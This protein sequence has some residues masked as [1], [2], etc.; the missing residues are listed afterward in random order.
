[1][2]K[3][4][5]KVGKEHR[6]PFNNINY[7]EINIGLFGSSNVSKTKFGFQFIYDSFY[8]NFYELYQTKLKTLN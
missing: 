3:E 1:M 6:N 5:I 2:Q 7:R 4:I 8:E